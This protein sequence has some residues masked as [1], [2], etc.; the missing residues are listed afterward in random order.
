MG[1]NKCLKQFY[2]KNKVASLVHLHSNPFLLIVLN[3]A[4]N[5]NWYFHWVI[6]FRSQIKTQL[7][8][9]SFKEAGIPIPTE[10]NSYPKMN[11]KRPLA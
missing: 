11:V 9:K 7:K 1:E 6:Y 10:H 5:F 4:S 3:S 2:D 8:R